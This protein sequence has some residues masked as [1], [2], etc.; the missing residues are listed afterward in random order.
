MRDTVRKVDYFSIQVPN[1]PGE[2]FR[3]LQ[4]LVTA[5]VNLLACTDLACSSTLQPL[6]RRAIAA[7]RGAPSRPGCASSATK[8]PARASIRHPSDGPRAKDARV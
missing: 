7:K 1:K 3:V 4:A 5:G 6:C 2:A 8:A